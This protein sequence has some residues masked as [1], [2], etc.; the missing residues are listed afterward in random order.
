MVAR[1]GFEPPTPAFSGLYSREETA[2]ISITSRFQ[3]LFIC[4]HNVPNGTHAVFALQNWAHHVF[5]VAEFVEAK[6]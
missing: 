3:T 4:T 6:D 2:L 5:E 1:D